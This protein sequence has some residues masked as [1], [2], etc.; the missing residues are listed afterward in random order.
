MMDDFDEE[1]AV[2]RHKITQ[3]YEICGLLLFYISA[4]EKT[5]GK[6]KMVDEKAGL[7]I[8]ENDALVEQ[9]INC[10]VESSR[11]FEATVRVYCAMLTQLS[12]QTGESEARLADALM[13]MIAEVRLTPP[14]L[15]KMSSA[16]RNVISSF[17]SNGPREPWRKPPC[18]LVRSWTM[19][20]R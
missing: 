3:I 14:G 12:S 15:P 16:L 13:V 9:I 19:P 17:L 8:S 20:W 2:V 10:L 1:G 5:F 11:A 6:L 7:S 18:R 4:M